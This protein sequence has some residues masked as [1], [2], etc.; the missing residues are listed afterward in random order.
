MTGPQGNMNKM[1]RWLK[2]RKKV[3]GDKKPNTVDDDYGFRKKHI[4]VQETENGH[5][6]I[7]R[8]NGTTLVYP[9]SFCKLNYRARMPTP[10]QTYRE[11]SSHIYDEI[12]EL[13][14]R[15]RLDMDTA[16]QEVDILKDTRERCE[17]H[18]DFRHAIEVGPYLIV[19]IV[20]STN[21]KD[22]EIFKRNESQCKKESFVEKRSTRLC[23][24]TTTCNC[25]ETPDLCSQWNDLSVRGPTDDKNEFSILKD[26]T[27]VLT[28]C[29]KSKAE[30]TMNEKKDATASTTFETDLCSFDGGAFNVNI[31]FR[32][33]PES[34]GAESHSKTLIETPEYLTKTSDNLSE[35]PDS[36]A[37]TADKETVELSSVQNVDITDIV[38]NLDCNAACGEHDCSTSGESDLSSAGDYTVYLSRI[39]NNLK[40]KHDVREMIKNGEKT[41]S[42]SDEEEFMENNDAETM[43]YVSSLSECSS[44]T[45][46]VSDVSADRSS[47]D[48]SI[49]YHECNEPKSTSRTGIGETRVNLERS[50]SA[51]MASSSHVKKV[52]KINHKFQRDKKSSKAKKNQQSPRSNSFDCNFYKA[53][54]DEDKEMYLFPSNNDSENSVSSGARHT[55]NKP[56]LTPQPTPVY[57]EP[58]RGKSRSHNRLLGDLIRMNYDKQLF[59]H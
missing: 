7:I 40:L 31:D 48:E 35:K 43:T 55:R 26:A 53:L 52:L 11:T 56:V 24:C 5:S 3:K 39:E 15:K 27:V 37:I 29:V 33:H 36:S 18:I 46:H 41:I 49:K 23:G 9:Q 54:S 32:S 59:I 4:I 10:I 14:A 6:V 2:D 19:P 45:S 51:P 8:D 44:A 20:N 22:V 50:V 12:P 34:F 38:G 1:F 28:R 42:E 57:M 16:E 47:S 17:D 58:Y 30:F 21:S 13:P 25:S